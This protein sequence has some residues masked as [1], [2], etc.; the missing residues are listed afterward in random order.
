VSR[1]RQ[2]A[3]DPVT[4][5]LVAG[6]LRSLQAEMERLLERSA[7]SPFIHEKK[8]YFA[9]VATAAGRLLIGDNYTSYGNVMDAVLE[10]YPAETMRPGDIYAYNDCYGSNGGVT[11]SPDIVF[12][13][14]V[15]DGPALVGFVHC[16][17]HF[18]DIGGMRAGSL[19]ADATDIF[20]EGIIIP[21]VRIVTAGVQSDELVRIL[22][23]N[24][25]FPT[26]IEN[27]L[28]ALL[29]ATRLGVH[30]VLELCARHGR[31]VVAGAFDRALQ[32]T[33]AYVDAALRQLIPD[34][35]Y[36][37]D[38]AVDGDAIGDEPIWIRLELTSRAGRRV[39]DTRDSAD[40]TR[41]PANY[42]MHHTV[43]SFALALLVLGE[44]TGPQHNGGSDSALQEVLVR[45]GSVLRPR[46]PAALGSRG[47]TKMRLQSALM[48]CVAR[49]T[50]GRSPAASAGY[51]LYVLRGF[52][53]RTR[54]YFL[55]TDGLA[56]GH[57]ARPTADGLDAIYG[58]GQRNYPVE[59][60]PWRFPLRVERYAINTDSGGPGRFRGGCGIV[61]E[62]RLL[63]PE[64]TLACR[65][66][67]VRMPAYGVAGG[68]AGRGGAVTVN[69]GQPDERA[70]ATLSDGTAIRRN[71]VIRFETAGGGGWGHPFERA[72]E[73]VEADVRCGFVSIDSARLDYG[74][75]IDPETLRVDRRSTARRRRRQ[76]VTKLFHRGT[77]FD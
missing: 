62:V 15:I 1:A 33:A 70:V 18:W 6:G 71:D 34:G 5:A 63:G 26:V 75:V 56:V 25:R 51:S 55:C 27:D 31:A 30:R 73:Q 19:S 7:M 4:R 41:G 65:L 24:T 38:E 40:Q 43:P 20:Q 57:G 42:L 14:P 50:G 36:R 67:N 45:E 2:P 53:V 35:T 66:D 21:P 11:H 17:G 12:V 32:D 22:L 49:A 39:L 54:R 3:D 13:A 23:S 29:A 76:P 59:Y 37:F 28:Q 68:L 52:D 16:A 9:G 60:V 74:V 77:Y 64:A 10:H 61:R 48:G 8:D 69:P 47:Q 46:W 44:A 58:P 72:A